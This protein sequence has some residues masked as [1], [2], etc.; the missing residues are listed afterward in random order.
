VHAIS[1]ASILAKTARDAAL[2]RCCTRSIRSTASTSTRAT[3]ALHLERL[4]CTAPS[5]VH[6]RSFAPVRAVHRAARGADG[7]RR[8][9]GMKTITSRD[10]PL[11]KELKQLAT[12]SQARR[13]AGRTLLDG[14]HLCQ[15]WLRAARPAGALRGVRGRAAQSRSADIVGRCEALH[16]HVTACR[17]RCTTRSA[18]SSMAST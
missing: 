17:T 14:V 15:S 12:S 9:G 2:V 1:A 4:R 5:P 8:E 13:K 11:Y 3:T 16:A 10:N 18:R 6:R 7:L